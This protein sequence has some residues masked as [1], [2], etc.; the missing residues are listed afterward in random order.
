MFFGCCQRLGAGRCFVLPPCSCSCRYPRLHALRQPRVIWCK[1]LI[2]AS[3]GGRIIPSGVPACPSSCRDPAWLWWCLFPVSPRQQV[4]RH[5][6][7]K[8]ALASGARPRKPPGSP[9]AIASSPVPAPP[10]LGSGFTSPVPA[11][12]SGELPESRRG[13]TGQPW[14]SRTPYGDVEH[15]RLDGPSRDPQKQGSLRQPPRAAPP[16]FSLVTPAP[17]SASSLPKAWASPPPP[18]KGSTPLAP[19]DPKRSSSGAAGYPWG[20]GPAPGFPS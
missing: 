13:D 4:Q 19:S 2:P 20:L 6:Q 11:E 9:R 12:G 3:R 1:W 8:A 5:A 15:Q 7:L 16:R 14:P 18:A 10:P 17:S